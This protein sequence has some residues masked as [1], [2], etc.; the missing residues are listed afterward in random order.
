MKKET[1]QL[2]LELTIKLVAFKKMINH[3]EEHLE[4]MKD[5]YLDLGVRYS[6]LSGGIKED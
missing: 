6:R 4:A 3:I 1:E 5:M 2:V